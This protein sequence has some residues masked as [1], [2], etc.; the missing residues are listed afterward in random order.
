MKKLLAILSISLL[1]FHIKQADSHGLLLIPPARSS[2]WREDPARF[3]SFYGDNQMFCGGVNT[4]WGQN[5]WF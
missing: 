5:S 3:P 4:Q 2:A 1:L